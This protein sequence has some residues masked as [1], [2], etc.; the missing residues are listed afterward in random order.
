M[1]TKANIVYNK[2]IRFTQEYIIVYERIKND[3]CGNPRYQVDIF[4]N[5]G[6]PTTESSNFISFVCTSYN[7]TNEEINKYIEK[8]N[9][10]FNTD[11]NPI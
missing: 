2:R 11:W 3:T 6:K 1:I 10:K 5:Y 7:L 8:W 9:K 4:C